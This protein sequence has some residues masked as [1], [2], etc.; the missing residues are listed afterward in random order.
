MARVSKRKYSTLPKNVLSDEEL[1]VF[2]KL[3]NYE[4]Y[5]KELIRDILIIARLYDRNYKRLHNEEN[6]SRKQMY[7]V[8][9]KCLNDLSIQLRKLASIRLTLE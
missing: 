7:L 9:E 5:N 4:A 6:Y 2:L 8:A 3:N 1:S